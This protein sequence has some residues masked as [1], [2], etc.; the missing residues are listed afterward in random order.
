MNSS[1]GRIRTVLTL[2]AGLCAG[3]FPVSARAQAGVKQVVT[4]PGAAANAMLSAGIRVGNLLF[5]S[6]QLGGSDSTTEG[7]TKQSLD[8]MKK[9]L[10]AAGTTVDNV[11]KCTVF[12]IDMKDFSK[13]NEAYRTF[14]ATNGAKDMPGRSTVAVAGLARPSAKIEIECIAVMPK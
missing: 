1:V 2:V 3:V 6:G 12:L 8:N 10:D 4:V 13:M 11:V 14:F 7:Q 5:M 9:V